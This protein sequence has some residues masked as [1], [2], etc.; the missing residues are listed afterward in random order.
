MKNYDDDDNDCVEK[1]TALPFFTFAAIAFTTNAAA[2]A[3]MLIK[4]I[5]FLAHFP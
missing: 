2:T 5:F 3:V 1:R 4:Y